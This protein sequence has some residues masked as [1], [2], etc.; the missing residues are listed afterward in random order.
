MSSVRYL[1]ALMLKKLREKLFI[2]IAIAAAIGVAFSLYA[3]TAQLKSALLLFSYETL[4][5]IMGLVLL[6]Y[7]FR[8]ARWEYYL[9]V[10]KIKI[11]VSESFGIFM[12]S[13]AMAV[14]PGKMGEV[15]KSYFLK[16]LHGTPMS[17]SMPIVFAERVTDFLALL[18]IS[19]IGAYEIG[20]GKK[21]IVILALVFAAGIAVI[22]SRSASTKIIHLIEKIPVIAKRIVLIENA[23]ESSRT[24]LSGEKLFY[25]TV[26][27]LIGWSFECAGFFFVL[28]GL[29]IHLRIL[30]SDFIYAFST[31]VGAIS[32]LPGGLGATETSLAGLL[33][34]AKIPKGEAVA[35]VFIIRAATLWFAVFIGVM[36]LSYMQ[37]RY[38]VALNNKLE[39]GSSAPGINEVEKL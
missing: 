17:K 5:V 39:N 29:N 18:I 28:E 8:F 20:Y 1:F 32:F 27:G 34:L 24:M 35:A 4:P 25:S 12:S 16:S 3:N 21:L 19:F 11:P 10:L 14:T 15:L 22:A 37:K 30:S 38:G 33:V 31:V 36:V 26:L 9:R 7:F 2:S 13:L 23:Y 6:N